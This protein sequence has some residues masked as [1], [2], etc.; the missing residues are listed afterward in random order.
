MVNGWCW[1]LRGLV[2]GRD[3]LKGLLILR[4]VIGYADTHVTDFHFRTI[5]T[6]IAEGAAVSIYT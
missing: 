3:L 6:S 5:I 4:A 2:K 1:F